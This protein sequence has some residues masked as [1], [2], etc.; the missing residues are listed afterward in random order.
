MERGEA[1]A[2][3]AYR[4]DATMNSRVQI[5]EYL[6]SALHPEIVYPIAVVGEQNPKFEILSMFSF[7]LT[8]PAVAIFEKNGF[9]RLDTQC[10][11]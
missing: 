8:P 4:S 11:H 6:P 5:S 3:Y 1:N 9:R 10:P 7:M 2:G